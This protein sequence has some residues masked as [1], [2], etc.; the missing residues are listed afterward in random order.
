ML[1]KLIKNEYK[2]TARLILPLYLL[3][4]IIT[5]LNKL[6]FVIDEDPVSIIAQ[7]GVFIAFAAILMITYVLSL[8]AVGAMTIIFIIKR[9][10][11]SMLKDEGYLS[12]TLPVTTGQHL[13]SKIIVSYSWLVATIAAILTSVN[14]LL[15]AYGMR[16]FW[17]ELWRDLSEVIKDGNQLTFC[18]V[19]V[20]IILSL[21]NMIIIPYVCFSVGQRFNGHKVL[22][23]FVTYIVIYMI[24]QIIGVIVMVALVSGNIDMLETMGDAQVFSWAMK[25]EFLLILAESTIF[26]IVTHHMLDKKLNLD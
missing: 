7:S 1:G 22:G 20:L 19:V 15:G 18:I 6:V 12:F 3:L 2:A 11:D 26:T 9:F 21:Y 13:A 16:G 23:A 10:Y 17:S 4:L 14:I 8:F 25:Y 24:N 5:G